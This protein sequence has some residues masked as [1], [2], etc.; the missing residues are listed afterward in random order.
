MLN[1]DDEFK[2]TTYDKNECTDNIKC[3]KVKQALNLIGGEIN[4]IDDIVHRVKY[5]IENNFPQLENEDFSNIRLMINNLKQQRQEINEIQQS[6]NIYLK[7]FSELRENQSKTIKQIE[8]LETSVNE[9]FESFDYLENEKK[10]PNE[11]IQKEEEKLKNRNRKQEKDFNKMMEWI[12]KLKDKKTNRE[13]NCRIDKLE[14]EKYQDRSMLIYAIKQIKEVI[15]M[16]TILDSRKLLKSP[17][18]DPTEEIENASDT[19]I[20]TSFS[21][22]KCSTMKNSTGS[23]NWKRNKNLFPKFLQKCD[24]KISPKCDNFLLPQ[25]DQSTFLYYNN[26]SLRNYLTR[27]DIPFFLKLIGKNLEK[28]EIKLMKLGNQYFRIQ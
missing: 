11:K 25:K 5:S 23:E 18:K 1:E 27:K 13:E 14:M 28:R 3:C 2:I 20:E 22:T 19:K 7:Q 24:K 21:H 8:E 4:K 15:E 6:Y 26:N 9:I 12:S 16:K 10:I 17:K